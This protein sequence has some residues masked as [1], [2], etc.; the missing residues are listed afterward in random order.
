[1]KNLSILMASTLSE[2]F[3]LRADLVAVGS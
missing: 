1:M 3:L 2:F